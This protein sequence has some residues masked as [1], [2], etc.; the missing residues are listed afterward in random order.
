MKK[1]TLS[2]KII[3]QKGRDKETNKQY[4]FNDRRHEDGRT[5]YSVE[6][7]SSYFVKDI[8]IFIFFAI[9]I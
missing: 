2:Q 1:N 6:V 7:T 4:E 8:Q 5:M 3:K 9:T